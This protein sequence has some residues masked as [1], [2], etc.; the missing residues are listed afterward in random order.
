MSI[1]VNN[2]TVSYNVRPA[3]HHVDMEFPQHC[4]YAIFGPN[5][6]GKSTLLKAIMGLLRCD[7]GS[8]QWQGMTRRDIAYL[9]QQ[10]DVDRSQPMTVFE[11]AAMGLWYEIGFFGGVTAAQRE[12]VQAALNR[13]E[14]GE[15]AERG[16]GELSN[17]QFQRVLF[18]RMLVQDAK[19][20]LLDEPF[21]AVDA[22][23]TYAML[24]LLRQENQA[25]RA[26]VAVLHDYE[27]VRA[28]F[29][30]TF[31]I[32]REKVACGKTETVLQDEWLNKASMLA[33]AA[34][35]DEW[36]AV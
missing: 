36:C 2:L 21:N 30:N 1:V 16:I 33:Q 5:G 15:F 25:G 12:R 29:P 9:P 32:A 31:L 23:T 13:V 28:Y 7:T 24:E 6:A 18:A 3:V 14:M 17:G 20:L 34:D 35:E 26:V 4:M 22:K 27:Q 10:S 19:F 11:L 8:V